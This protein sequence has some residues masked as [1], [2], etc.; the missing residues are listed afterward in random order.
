MC[1][2]ASPGNAWRRP[3]IPVEPPSPTAF[4]IKITWDSS[5]NTAPAGFTT[6]ILAAVRYLESE[7]DNP[8]TINVN[9][10]YGEIANGTLAGGDLGE[11][12]TFL[13]S[14]SYTALRG[15]LIAG[16]RTRSIPAWCSRCLGRARWPAPI[17]G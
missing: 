14:V 15:A 3:N 6:D 9:V 10:G 12:E 17:T 4:T 2:Q 5:V 13:Q 16:V 8:V 7:F 1:R 11:S